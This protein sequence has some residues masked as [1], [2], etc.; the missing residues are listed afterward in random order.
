ME[1]QRNAAVLL[2]GGVFYTFISL[3]PQ[4]WDIFS[5]TDIDYRTHKA[6]FFIKNKFRL[7]GVRVSIEHSKTGIFSIKTAKKR[8]FFVL[9][10]IQSVISTS[11]ANY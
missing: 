10:Y 6:T 5:Y 7:Q 1:A 9:R 4:I 8:P 2:N 11:I 3:Y